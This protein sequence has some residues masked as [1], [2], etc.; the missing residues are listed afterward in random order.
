MPSHSKSESAPTA[1]TG[2][3]TNSAYSAIAGAA[4]HQ[5]W[6][7]SL[8][9]GVGL[10]GWPGVPGEAPFAGDAEE[11]GS[12]GAEEPGSPRQ[13]RF[14]GNARVQRGSGAEERIL[15]SGRCGAAASGW[16]G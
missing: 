14:G 6:N 5:G 12:R 4:S 9:V 1:I 11:Q 15:V 7:C 16:Y 3:M 10:I 13:V 2:P 8:R